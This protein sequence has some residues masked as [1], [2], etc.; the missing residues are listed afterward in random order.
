M[1]RKNW[2]QKVKEKLSCPC[3]YHL[4]PCFINKN[5]IAVL[6]RL[7][8]ITHYTAIALTYKIKATG[9]WRVGEKMVLVF[10]CFFVVC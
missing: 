3:S 9:S 1:Y 7:T 4:V 10:F 5:D 8:L 2:W 6:Q